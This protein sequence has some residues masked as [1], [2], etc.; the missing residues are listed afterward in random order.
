M[1]NIEYKCSN[2]GRHLDAQFEYCPSCGSKLT[3]NNDALAIPTKPR[4]YIASFVLG[5]ISIIF[6]TL[7]LIAL[8]LGSIPLVGWILVMPFVMTFLLV[9]FVTSI[10]SFCVRCKNRDCFGITRVGRILALIAFIFS[11]LIIVLFVVSFIT[12]GIFLISNAGKTAGTAKLLFIL[13]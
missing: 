4:K 3:Y 13:L 9:G 12:V 6:N 2:C 1:E 5:L 8:P 11:M 10:I 7:G